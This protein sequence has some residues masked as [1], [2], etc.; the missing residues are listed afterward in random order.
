[1]S[2][3]VVIPWRPGCPYREAALDIV[4]DRL[5]HTHP[6]WDLVLGHHVDGPWCKAAAIADAL[7]RT[8]AD[9]LI[10]HDADVWCDDLA[11]AVDALDS[12]TRWAIPHDKVWRL[13]QGQLE[14]T[15]DRSRLARSVYVGYAGGG[16]TVLPRAVYDA[17]PM[18]PRFVGWGQEDES[19]AKALFALH[20]PYW[21]GNAPLWHFWHPPQERANQR[22]GSPAGVALAH[23]YTRAERDPDAMAQLI[24]EARHALTAA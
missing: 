9:T 17:C 21:R 24:E 10:I 11:A 4:T 5:V 14:P 8:G 6:G 18:D 12:T 1:M 13:R 22:H 16:I 15:L 2:V 23:R 19:W 3:A 7:D 20:G